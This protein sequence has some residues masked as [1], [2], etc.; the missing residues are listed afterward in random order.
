MKREISAIQVV[1]ARTT[2]TGDTL[3]LVLLDEAGE[4]N[5][6]HLP[7]DQLALLSSWLD[8]AGNHAGTGP[9]H[10]KAAAPTLA[11]ERWTIQPEADEE[12]LLLGFK[13]A[14][15]AE[16]NLRMH[17]NAVSAYIKAL[18]SVLGRTLPASPSKAKH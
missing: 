1:S 3:R 13:M 9:G 14:K 8:Q 15:G 7:L 6:V 4:E 17:R 10:V 5:L 16:I 18:A 11:V 12:H 2:E